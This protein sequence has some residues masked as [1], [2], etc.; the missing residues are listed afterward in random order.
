MLLQG[1]S[2]PLLTAG[3]SNNGTTSVTIPPS[4]ADGVYY[5]IAK[6]DGDRRRGRVQRDQQYPQRC[7]PHR[8]RPRDHGDYGTSQG[9][10]GSLDRRHRDDAEHGTGN[11][12]ASVTAFYLSTNALLEASDTAAWVTQR[13]GAGTECDERAHHERRA[14]VREPGTW[15][16]IVNAD[17]ERTVAETVGNQQRARPSVCWWVRI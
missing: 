3:S 7:P 4:T 14:A 1:R 13:S 15:Y 11:A 2:V 12:G 5:L 10:R 8:S 16:L 17:D 9:G 6:A